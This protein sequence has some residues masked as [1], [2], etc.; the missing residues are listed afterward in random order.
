AA[1]PP[2]GG[3]VRGQRAVPAAATVRGHLTG[4][5][6]GWPTQR[7]TDRPHR[8]PPA[9]TA[10]DDKPFLQVQTTSRHATPPQTIMGVATTPRIHLHELHGPVDSTGTNNSC[11]IAGKE[12][13]GG[14]GVAA[15]EVAAA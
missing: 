6:R 9:Q 7:L 14:E 12:G 15:V 2:A 13:S 8:P 11:M 10:L 5:R 1:C 4:D 3:P